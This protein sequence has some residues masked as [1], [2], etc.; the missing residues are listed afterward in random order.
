MNTNWY[1]RLWSWKFNDITSKWGRSST[2]QDWS[3]LGRASERQTSAVTADTIGAKP[4]PVDVFRQGHTGTISVHL[5]GV[6]A[7]IVVI[8]V[9]G[10]KN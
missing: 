2:G 1:L 4:N 7:S 5:K 3:V 10:S 9:N 6:I 8:T